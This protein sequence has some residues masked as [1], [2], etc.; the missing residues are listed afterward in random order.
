MT[1]DTY[2]AYC[3]YIGISLYSNAYLIYGLAYIVNLHSLHKFYCTLL[4]LNT[5]QLAHYII[6]LNK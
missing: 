1:Y 6:F 3:A 4:G 2:D 5:C